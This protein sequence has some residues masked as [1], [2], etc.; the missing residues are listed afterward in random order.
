MR[1]RD[2]MPG[3]CIYLLGNEKAKFRLNRRTSGSLALHLKGHL[4]SEHF[5]V[6]IYVFPGP[7]PKDGCS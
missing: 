7:V 3:N 2:N 5:L 1:I 4:E 6:M